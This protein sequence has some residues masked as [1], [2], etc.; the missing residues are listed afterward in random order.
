VKVHTIPDVPPDTERRWSDARL[1]TACRAGSENAWAALLDR[2]QNLIFSIPL[3]YG[4]S[5]PDAADIFQA[6]CLDLL[7]ELPQL[8]NPQALPKWLMQTTARKCWRLRRR[9]ARY[10][11]E[12]DAAQRALDLVA[13][14]EHL[15]EEMLRELER[16]QGIR[17]AIAGLPPRCRQMIELLFFDV[18][19][20]RYSEVALALGV[21]TGSIG[22]LRLRCLGRLRRALEAAGV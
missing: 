16:E 21:A 18:P 10:A 8:R 9:E 13:S 2:Y 20:R 11:H 12:D 6:V 4:F 1:I 14:P 19:P 5:Q 22:L 15:P 3:K 7:T 17:E